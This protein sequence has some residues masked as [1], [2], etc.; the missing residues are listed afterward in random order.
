MKNEK[1][2]TVTPEQIEAWKQKHGD[3][4]ELS[5]EGVVGYIRKPDRKVMS[6]AST[7][8]ANDHIKYNEIIL[9]NCWL[10]GDERLKTDDAL[11]FG[12]TKELAKLIEVK[13]VELKKL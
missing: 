3:V 10:G 6:M 12:A 11:F 4:Y 1:T 8:G 2:T 9:S 5:Y 7:L 13:E